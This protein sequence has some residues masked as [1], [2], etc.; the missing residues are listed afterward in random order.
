MF[1]VV[2]W[3]RA[4]RDT[5]PEFCACPLP[6]TS[7]DPRRPTTHC[8]KCGHPKHPDWDQTDEQF[9]NFWMRIVSSYQGFVRPDYKV[10]GVQQTL[11]LQTAW[12]E[13]MGRDLY[14]YA[15]LAREN[16][17]EAREELA[18]C[19]VYLYEEVLRLRREGYEV[20]WDEVLEI[21]HGIIDIY[22][23][24]DDLRKKHRGVPT[25]T[26][27]PEP[28]DGDLSLHQTPPSPVG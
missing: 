6:S 10:P 9:H 7:S 25:A 16:G 5:L 15:Y 12:R 21:A 3:P 20:E 4:E 26:K 27:E 17:P 1:R 2:C 18:D 19:M 13:K 22:G 28:F 23:R 14:G 24:F 8:G 11:W